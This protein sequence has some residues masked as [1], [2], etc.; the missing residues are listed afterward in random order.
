MYRPPKID[1]SA[2]ALQVLPEA[3]DRLLSQ[4][5][6]HFGEYFF[7]Y[8]YAEYEL[9]NRLTIQPLRLNVAE[10]SPSK[11]Q[12]RVLRR[13]ADLRVEV[14]PV[15]ITRAMRTI[16]HE[17]KQRFTSNVPDSL[18]NFLGDRPGEVVNCLAFQAMQGTRLLA[19]SFMDVG[20]TS[21]SSVYA[22]FDPEEAHRSLGLFTMLEELR[23]CAENGKTYYYPGYGSV[24]PSNYDYKKDFKKLWHL[25]WASMTWVPLPPGESDGESE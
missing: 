13:N 5:W 9:G 23:W 12:R 14:G 3:F 17:H 25:D 20:E 6:R 22:V 24:E 8:S 11:N 4:G 16:F 7:R 19:A 21:V 2:Y 18:E 10:F 1:E 15:A